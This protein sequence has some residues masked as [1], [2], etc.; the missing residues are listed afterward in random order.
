[1]ESIEQQR[2]GMNET[3]EESTE[4]QERLWID[5]NLTQFDD[6]LRINYDKPLEDFTEAVICHIATITNALRGVF[7]ILNNEKTQLD[8]FGGFACTSETM[9]K[10]SFKIGEGLI[11]QSV[12]SKKIN[13]IQNLPLFNL[14]LEAASGQ[15]SAGSMMIIPLVFNGEVYGVLELAYLENLQRKYLHLLERAGNNVAAMLQSIQTNIRTKQLLE[16]TQEQTNTLRTQEEELRQNLE[17]LSATQNQLI[18]IQKELEQEVQKSK[19]IF[20]SSRDAI[21]VMKEDGSFTDVNEATLIL[22][23]YSNKSD[24]LGQTPISISPAKQE[25]H[26][27]RSSEEVATEIMQATLKTGKYTHEWH[28]QKRDGQLFHAEVK[29]VSF[30]LQ[31]KT[32]MQFVVRDI[33]EKKAQ[34]FELQTAYEELKTQEEELRQNVEELSTTQNKIL[35][36]QNELEQEVQKS[37]AIFESSRDAVIV[38]KEDGSFTDVNEA[39]LILFDYS[40]KSDLLGQTPISISPAKQELHNNRSSE[41]VA[42][43]IM[44]ATLKTGKYTHEWHFQ[45][46]DGQLFHAEVKLVS[47]QL[48]DEAY[49]QFVVRDITEKK[50]QEFELQTAYEELKTQEEELRQ[51]LKELNITQNQLIGIQKELER[52]VQKSKT[53]FES[54]R[55][56]V[57]VMKE[58]GSFTDVNEAT[59]ILFDYSNKSDLLGQTPISISPAKQ[60]LH[61]NRSS[62]EVATEIMQATLKT[63]KYTHEWHFQKRDGQLFHAEVKLVS[64]QLHDE[65][66]MQFV[67]RDITEKKAVLNANVDL[68]T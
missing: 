12:K 22:F 26:N 60:E 7:F 33:T 5:S 30:Q 35:T 28:F 67:V 31:G 15:L 64:F 17:E 13:I 42:T 57:I 51:N 65:A 16:E 8:A 34:E 14:T 19:I 48:Q 49:M 62:E 39:T 54:S 2:N 24:L 36:I 53:I 11:G 61:N 20:E 10:S 44:Q 55:D 47:F 58:D 38:M 9:P 1:M 56:A 52:E 50:A 3:I 6:I 40:N 21:I 25:L 37:K 27:N 68:K 46:R 43:E 18:H 29:L 32:Y 45:K 23:D 63:G 41:E 59:L 66:Y 4:I